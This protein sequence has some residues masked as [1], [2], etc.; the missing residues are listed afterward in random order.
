LDCKI[1]QVKVI[2]IEISPRYHFDLVGRT[3][4]SLTCFSLKTDFCT[5]RRDCPI[6]PWR[7]GGDEA[8]IQTRGESW[9]SCLERRPRL[10]PLARPRGTNWFG[11]TNKRTEPL[12]LI[13]LMLT[14]RH[15]V[16]GGGGRELIP[17][18]WPQCPS[19][20]RVEAPR[21][22]SQPW[23]RRIQVAKLCLPR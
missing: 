15:C 13:Y 23:H 1:N 14:L 3:T 9:G 10:T 18:A 20:E 21:P 6:C 17:R 22:P 19:P 4:Q 7:G 5:Q 16:E 11:Y 2:S 8:K 12:S